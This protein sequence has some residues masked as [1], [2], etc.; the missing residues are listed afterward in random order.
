[1]GSPLREGERVQKGHERSA[2]EVTT[3]VGGRRPAEIL[4]RDSPD[5]PQ[6]SLG[7]S[8]HLEPPTT[9]DMGGL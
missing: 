8:L 4:W 3:C 6:F 5:K 9:E 2:G 7:K 1:M